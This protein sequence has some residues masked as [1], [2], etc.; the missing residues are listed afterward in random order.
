MAILVGIKRNFITPNQG[1]QQLEKNN[2]PQNAFAAAGI[3]HPSPHQSSPL[4]GL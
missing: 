3:P 2:L 4:F 1:L